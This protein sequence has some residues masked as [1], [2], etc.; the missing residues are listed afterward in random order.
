MNKYSIK[1]IEKLYPIKKVNI[2]DDEVF[3]YLRIIGLNG[4]KYEDR[5]SNVLFFLSYP[6][7]DELNNGWY[8]V[9]FD[10]RPNLLDI[11]NK[12]P[13]YTFVIEEGMEDICLSQMK[14]IIVDSIRS[15]INSLYEYVLGKASAKVISFTGSVG[16]TTAV[17]LLENVLKQKYNVLRIYSKRITPINLQANIINFLNGNVDFIVL[18]NSLYYHN[19]V[20]ILSTLL[21]PYICV[22]L[23]IESSHLGVERLKSIEDICT[24]KSEIMR[25]AKYAFLNFDD[26]CLKKIKKIDGGVYFGNKHLFDNNNLS[27]NYISADSVKVDEDTF[28]VDGLSIKPFI[29]SNLSMIQY[30]MCFRIAKLC[31]LNDEKI[32]DG[33]SS[34]KPVENRLQTELAFGREI[35]FDGDVTT[36]ERM[37]EL[38]NILYDKKYLVLRKVGSAE[39]TFRIGNIVDFFSRFDKVFVFS[40]IDYLDEFKMEENVTIV[41]N[42][43][44]MNDLDG[45]II[46]HY[47]GYYRVWDNFDEDNLK[48]YD[49]EKYIIIKDD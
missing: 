37:D 12:H 8:T 13:N 6:T 43:D 28:I 18:E 41:S 5:A 47:S 20:K 1:E 22:I 45:K 2:S 9:N 33:L 4:I 26:D 35:I 40:D 38:S 21:K 49:R 19:H 46:Y 7:N 27:I 39:N 23:N 36:Y 17:G 31:G 24:F 34:Y 15:F 44:F 42:H 14:Y 48:I 25:Y 32:V 10:L 29:L 11:Y 16:K 3:D 30:L